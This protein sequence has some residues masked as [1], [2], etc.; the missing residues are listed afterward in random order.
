M[1]NAVD[2]TPPPIRCKLSADARFSQVD[3]ANDHTWELTTVQ[4]DPP[5]LMLQTTYGLRGHWMRIFPSFSAGNATLTDPGSFSGFP[6][7]STTTPSYVRVAFAPFPNFDVLME[8]YVPSSNVICGKIS[9]TNS[10]TSLQNW[11]LSFNAVLNPLNRGQRMTPGVYG[12][13]TVL[14]GSTQNLAPVFYI[15][16]GPEP[17]LSPYAALSIPLTLQPERTR[18]FTWALASLHTLDESFNE[19]RQMTARPWDA[20]LLRLEMADRRNFYHVST[21]Q[22]EWDAVFAHSQRQAMQLLMCG[23]TRH[24]GKIFVLSRSPDH[25]YS[26]DGSGND[27][28]P[29]WIGQTALNTWT[30]C[31]LILPGHPE[32]A[33]ELL[34]SFLAAQHSDGFI[35]N[36]LE[37]SEHPSPDHA[38]PI[39]AD[40]AQLIE[41]FDPDPNWL[42]HIYPP[43]IQYLRRWFT[44]PAVQ[45]GEELPT[46][47]NPTQ[48][49]VD[50]LPEFSQDRTE[51]PAA[52]LSNL[53][54]PSLNALL[55]NECN[56]LIKFAKQLGIGD[57]LEWLEA[58]RQ[59]LIQAVEAC[60]N[61]QTR[62]YR[63]L[64]AQTGLLLQPQK[65][66][67][68]RQDGRVEINRELKAPGRVA[69]EVRPGFPI[70]ASMTIT[71]HG[72][73]N[74][75]PVTRKVTQ[76][77]FKWLPER[78]S[79]FCSTLF[80]A[81]NSISVQGLGQGTTLRV[82][83][84]GSNQEDITLLLP[85]W[86]G[87]P[88]QDR[89]DRLIQKTLLPRFLTDLGLSSSPRSRAGARLPA[90]AQVPLLW[91]LFIAKGL[92]RYGYLEASSGLIKTLI[93][94]SARQL[95]ST[96]TVSPAVSVGSAIP[97]GETDSLNS[98]LPSLDFVSVLGVE[99]WSD[100]G[101][102]IKNTNS[103]FR[104]IT[105]E[106]R[107]TTCEFLSAETVIQPA[108]GEAL[109]ISAPPAK[110]IL[111]QPG[112]ERN[113][114]ESIGD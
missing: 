54:S 50:N 80:E 11:R 95:A 32:I 66:A 9:I 78:G 72:R 108:G 37:L 79:L 48:A 10:S 106:Y 56:C 60:W 105:V 40:I 82:V 6:K 58:K 97:L 61:P 1:S 89:A 69:M 23:P 53:I 3:F 49:G 57:D 102:I 104:P 45:E 2:K 110:K 55:F 14:Q 41:E 29:A 12:L 51:G 94:Q 92:S 44:A 42:R 30:Y 85:L 4:T 19:A 24:P 36:S 101:M 109:K 18:T 43:L 28:Y 26:V 112:K 83:Q 22:P 35:S 107:R 17:L 84:P 34:D 91:N 103:F 87:M 68:I 70:P 90:D 75:I 7:L 76:K 96:G 77:D 8:I 86:A 100:S 65:L 5:S 99:G 38:F 67:T 64:D 74:G 52:Y 46:W 33:R 16:G 113:E 81:I 114:R 63:L 21:S 111:L 71:V 98:L 73:V 62:S 13:N 15:T 27:Y 31:K 93:I 25:G 47:S 59:A 39:L 20:D 88:G